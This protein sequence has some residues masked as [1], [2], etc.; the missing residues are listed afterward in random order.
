[1]KCNGA[2]VWILLP[3]LSGMIFSCKPNGLSEMPE[4]TKDSVPGEEIGKD[5]QRGRAEQMPT[6]SSKEYASRFRRLYTG[7]PLTILTGV[8]GPGKWRS[9]SSLRPDEYVLPD[10]HG[11]VY[12]ETDRYYSN[13]GSRFVAIIVWAGAKIHHRTSGTVEYMELE[14]KPR[15][16]VMDVHFSNKGSA[17]DTLLKSGS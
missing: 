5:G 17:G 7:L 15:P 9:Y 6:L 14:A 13:D 16:E 11:T 1:M 10:G 2:R 3:L 12:V 8:M 4:K